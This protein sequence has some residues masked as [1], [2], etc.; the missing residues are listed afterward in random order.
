[1]VVDAKFTVAG[2][3]INAVWPA[4]CGC[5]ILQAQKFMVH[6]EQY[7]SGNTFEVG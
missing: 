5:L 4:F 1:M 7:I 3:A 6:Q 2:V